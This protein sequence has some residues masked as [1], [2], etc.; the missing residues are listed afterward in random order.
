VHVPEAD[1]DDSTS[2]RAELRAP[3]RLREEFFGGLAVAL[4]LIPMVS[5]AHAASGSR[6]KRC[7][8]PLPPTT[9]R[10]RTRW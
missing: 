7:P 2:V 10:S 4:A 1:G 9:W 6:S 8:A 5:A 3:R